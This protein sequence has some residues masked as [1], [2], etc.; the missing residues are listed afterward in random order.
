MGPMSD[1]KLKRGSG[2]CLTHLICKMV[3]DADFTKV[4]ISPIDQNIQ[5]K[6]TEPL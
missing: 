2:L 5:D 3:L 1:K 4:Q 6:A